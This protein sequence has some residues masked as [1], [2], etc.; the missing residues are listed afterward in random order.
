MRGQV[1]PRSTGSSRIRVAFSLLFLTFRK[2]RTGGLMS[3]R[4]TLLLALFIGSTLVESSLVFG[5]SQANT[6]IIEGVVTDPAAR[7]VPKAEVTLVNTG[8]NFTRVLV[9]DEEGRFR[10]LLLPLGPYKVTVKAAN[11][12]TL[13]RQGLD[14]AVGQTISLTLSLGISQV[15]QVI[16]VT[17]ETPVI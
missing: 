2:D 13:V 12:G 6:G 1:K 8:T 3:A 10:G 7:A 9:T 15:E 11:F 14:L 17:S 16:S 5:Q 4:N